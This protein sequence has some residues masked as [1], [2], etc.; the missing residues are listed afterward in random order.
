MKTYKWIAIQ[1]CGFMQRIFLSASIFARGIF[2]PE[3]CPAWIFVRPEFLSDRKLFL[4]KAWMFARHF[5]FV[6]SETLNIFDHSPPLYTTEKL[7]EWFWVGHH[8]RSRDN[9][10]INWWTLDGINIRERRTPATNLQDDTRSPCRTRGWDIAFKTSR[11]K[12]SRSK[13]WRAFDREG[14]KLFLY[15]NLF[16]HGKKIA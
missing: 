11:S 2:C 4:W 10:K 13:S 9:L 7:S 12:T 16:W 5:I 15:F 1:D 6:R 8:S 3:F 14:I